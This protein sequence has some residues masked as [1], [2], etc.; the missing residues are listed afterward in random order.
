MIF[1]RNRLRTQSTKTIALDWESG[2]ILAFDKKPKAC[3]QPATWRHGNRIRRIG[4]KPGNNPSEKSMAKPGAR[5]RTR[6][7]IGVSA[8][9]RSCRS[10]PERT[11][12]SVQPSCERHNDELQCDSIPSFRRPPASSRSSGTR[13]A[14]GYLPSKILGC[15]KRARELEEDTQHPA[16]LMI[17]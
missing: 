1:S 2:E 6:L 9:T 7:R 11:V 10:R 13:C 4:S 16:F 5:S 14:L 3:P 17:T 8:T 15:V 12:L